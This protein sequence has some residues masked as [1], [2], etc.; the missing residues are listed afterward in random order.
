MKNILLPVVALCSSLAINGQH[1]SDNFENSTLSAWCQSNSG[2]WHIDTLNPINGTGSLHHNFNNTIAA[3]DMAILLHHPL[4]L[5]SAAAHWQFSIRYNYNPSSSNNWSCWLINSNGDEETQPGT[6]STGYALGVN[7]QG[8]DD[9]I[10]VWKRTHTGT[11]LVFATTFNWQASV[12]PGKTVKLKIDRDTAGSWKLA[13]DTSGIDEWFDIGSFIDTGFAEISGFGVYYKYTSTQDRKLWLDDVFIDGLFFSDKTPPHIDSLKAAGNNCMHIFFNEPVDTNCKFSIKLNGLNKSPLLQWRGNRTLTLVFDSVFLLNNVVEIYGLTDQKGNLSEKLDYSFFYYVPQKYDVLIT[14]I[15]AD[16]SPSAGLPECEFLEIVNCS[17]YDIHIGG[18]Q[19]FFN[20][21]PITF[22]EV[23]LKPSIPYLVIKSSCVVEFD[24]LLNKITFASLP[25]LTNSGMLLKLTNQHGQL[26]HAVEYTDNW[27]CDKSKKDGGWSLEL[28]DN[29]SACMGHINWAESI[30]ETGGTPGLPNSV[31]GETKDPHLP[32]VLSLCVTGKNSLKLT[33]N[34]DMDSASTIFPSNYRLMPG[35]N[36]P[37]AICPANFFCSEAELF[38]EGYFDKGIVYN[39]EIKDNML[40]DCSGNSMPGTD[41]IFGVA[42][43]ADSADIIINELLF[44]A[45]GFVPEFIELFNNSKKIID[46]NQ[47]AYALSDA[48][49]LSI[50]NP[51]MV[52]TQQLLI[53]PGEHI[54]FTE[55]KENLI[56]SFHTSP[57]KKVYEPQSWLSLPNSGKRIVLLDKSNNVIDAAI[58]N[59]GMHFKLLN[60]T[61]G[62]SLERISAGNVATEPQSWHSASESCGYATPAVKNSQALPAPSEN[63]SFLVNPSE[64]SPDNDGHNDFLTI[65][66]TFTEPGYLISVMVYNMS[67]NKVCTIANNELTGTEGILLWNGLDSNDN[68]LPFGYYVLFFEA[69][70][71]NEGIIRKKNTVLLLPQ[72]K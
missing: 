36:E 46:L 47:W 56:G 22:P 61:A 49:G 43:N 24:K 39:L 40:S 50:S 3:T 44:E 27:F 42:E 10:K 53:F 13:I 69:I 19:L 2:R 26:I 62:V 35:N 17:G 64:I 48:P 70:H 29:E 7:Y 72:N 31:E 55:N 5:D 32:Q 54:V 28:I 6:E 52:S 33:F 8:S 58:F 60:Q 38:F 1:L 12:L 66:Y 20:T 21:K 41:I 37:S 9:L 16:P 65:G 63:Y 15:L 68:R 59:T 23:T 30:S 51:A 45:T 14:E 34:N 57:A 71:P 25:A 4:M 18:W 11:E 67:G